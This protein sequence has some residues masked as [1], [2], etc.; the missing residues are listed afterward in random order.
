M[1]TGTEQQRMAEG[2]AVTDM[3]RMDYINSLPQPLFARKWGAS[4]W[5]W[6]VYDIDV[7]TGLYRIDVMGKLDACH[8]SD[9]AEFRDADGKSHDPETFYSDYV[10]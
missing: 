3:L 8:I 4:S 6:P 10:P 9:T 1:S 7:E 2:H 5:W